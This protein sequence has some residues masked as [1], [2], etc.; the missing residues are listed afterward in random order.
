M[1]GNND[2]IMDYIEPFGRIIDPKS[3]PVKSHE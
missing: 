1:T 3:Q 2:R